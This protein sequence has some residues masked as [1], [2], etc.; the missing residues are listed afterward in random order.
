MDRSAFIPGLAN[1]SGRRIAQDNI[2]IGTMIDINVEQDRQMLHQSIGIS[3][4]EC[5][6]HALVGDVRR[7]N[8]LM[9][10]CIPV[11]LRNHVSHPRA[12][13][14]E[15]RG[16]PC[17]LDHCRDLF[18]WNRCNAAIGIERNRFTGR[19]MT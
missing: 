11:R 13:E 18:G 8:D 17:R 12:I 5:A 16:G 19:D 10:R 6:G 3:H 7:R 2:A 9:A 1:N 4:A 15:Q 14:F